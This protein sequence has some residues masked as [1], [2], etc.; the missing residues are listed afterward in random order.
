M[1]LA[2]KR[3]MRDYIELQKDAKKLNLSA[4]PLEDN[5]FEWHVNI[6][7]ESGR[8]QGIIIHCILKFTENYPTDPPEVILSTG[9]PHS[10]IIKRDG[11]DYFLCLDMLKNFFWMDGGTDE[12]MI[13]SGWSSSYTVKILMMQLQTFLFDDYI[14]NYDGKIKHTLYQMAPEEGG[15]NRKKDTIKI[16]IENAFRDA[17]NF[18]CNK[19]GHCWNSPKPELHK[20]LPERKRIVIRKNIVQDGKVDDD[21]LKLLLKLNEE[22]NNLILDNLKDK[23]NSLKYYNN[24]GSITYID[25]C[26]CDYCRNYR[27]KLEEEKKDICIPIKK[28]EKKDICIPIKKE[29]TIEDELK[30]IILSINENYIWNIINKYNYDDELNYI[31]NTNSLTLEIKNQEIKSN[32]IDLTKIKYNLFLK[33]F[34]YLDYED[35]VKVSSINKKYKILCDDPYL[36]IR[37]EFICFYTKQSF[38]NTILGYGINVLFHRG[39]DTIKSIKPVLDLLSID[40]YNENNIRISVWNEEFRFWLPININSKHVNNAKNIIETNISNIYFS[41]YNDIEYKNKILKENNFKPKFL[42]DILCKLMSS[43]IVDMFKEDIFIST[44]ALNGFCEFHHLLI[45]FILWYPEIIDIANEK[46]YNFINTE[47]FTRKNKIPSLGDFLILLLVTNKYEWNDIK[48]KYKKESI[49]RNVMWVLKD[50]NDLNEIKDANEIFEIVKIGKRLF[51]FTIYFI[52]NVAPFCKHTYDKRYGRPPKEI[53]EDFQNKIKKIN[54][55]NTWEEYYKELGIYK[56][57]NSKI[58]YEYKIACNSSSQKRYHKITKN[59][60]SLES[61]D[62]VSYWRR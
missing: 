36:T 2:S 4:S 28:E 45:K 3:L 37:R 30:K 21:I 6:C 38:E 41:R 51:L 48:E 61:E 27:L 32:K 50:I 25:S 19:C 31:N 20:K 16:S 10:N 18:K 11:N 13:Y 59:P 29:E 56:S 1:N 23:L 55:I 39:S 52:N 40:A 35:I 26:N 5:L 58:I 42:L 60:R 7:P 8:Y 43:M 15:G 62:I 12:N 14:E 22:N 53:E 24:N 34:S 46:I 9:I 54:N 17:K 33:I 57:P 44:K 49:D 47:G